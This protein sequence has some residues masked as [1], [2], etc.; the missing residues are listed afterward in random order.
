VAGLAE[1]GYTLPIG[2]AM[3]NGTSMASPE[4]AGGAALLLSAARAK[5]K[6]VTPAQLR[7]A[8]YTSADQIKGESVAGQGNGLMDVNGAWSLLSKEI[9]TARYESS[10]QV[11]TALSDF[12]A[13]PGRG[14]GIHNRCAAGEGG[15]RA[16]Q[17][18]V[19]NVQIKRTSGSSKSIKHKLIWVGDKGQFRSAGSVSLPLNKAVTVPVTV[20][21]KEGL[22]SAILRVDDPATAVVDYEI[23]NT[24]VTSVAPK[25]PSFAA[26]NEGSVER[27]STT[28]YFVTVPEGATSLQVDLSGIATGS[29]TRWIAFNPYGVPVENTSSPFCY[30]NYSDPAT[31]KPQERSYDD[32][33]PGVWELEVE[34]RR[35]TPS[36]NNPFQ[37]TAKV[38]GVTVTP[39]T[40]TLDSVEAGTPTPVT[41]T[42]KNNFGPIVLGAQGGSLGSAKVDRP[43]IAD[44]ESQEFEVVVPEGAE[45]LDVSIGNPSDV[46]ADLDLTVYLGD[47]QVAQQADGD[48]EE[49]VSIPSPAAGTY[50]VVVDGYSVPSG[51]TQYDYRDVYYSSALGTI[52][53]PASATPLANGASTTVT[54]TVTAAAAPPAG[55]SL[56]GEVA[57]VT[58][59]GAVVGRGSVQIGAVS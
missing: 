57:F 10:A 9:S 15:Q 24:V 25:K 36:L 1:A 48:A 54:G 33:L 43:T 40:V 3:E 14:V 50:T 30:T 52:A 8:L 28:S 7:R 12:L 44:Q 45:R 13:T 26:V 29:Q 46:A 55:R 5:D 4:A 59:E 41:W 20:T 19:Y 21:A 58:S 32:P 27:N 31:C 53:V 51:S 38:Q 47:T 22:N 17:T 42:V 16:G 2:L 23:L 18:R 11:C 35:T 39:E 34:A 56:F 37:L 49:A 6:A